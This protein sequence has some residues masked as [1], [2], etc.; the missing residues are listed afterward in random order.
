[1]FIFIT[2]LHVIFKDNN[3]IA[4]YLYGNHIYLI[5]EYFAGFKVF[6]SSQQ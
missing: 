4:L 5:P 1:M 3:T 6:V 2:V